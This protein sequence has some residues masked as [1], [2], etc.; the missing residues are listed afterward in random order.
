[1]PLSPTQQQQSKY[2]RA[3]PHLSPTNSV[4]L[5]WMTTGEVGSR[6]VV[7]QYF[8]SALRHVVT[9]AWLNTSNGV[10]GLNRNW[11]LSVRVVNE[12]ERKRR[13]PQARGSRRRRLLGGEVWGGVSPPHRGR[14]AVPLSRIFFWFWLSI[15]WVLVHSGW[16]FLTVQLPV[17]HAKPELNR[18]RRIKAVMVSRWDSARP[19]S[20]HSLRTR[21]GWSKMCSFI[22]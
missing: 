17:L 5:R 13:A 2:V 16:Y 14:G 19:W 4:G 21:L 10:D 11:H 20:L 12:K 7:F 9:C 3:S 15:W 8:T 1:M 18:Y 6:L 22:V